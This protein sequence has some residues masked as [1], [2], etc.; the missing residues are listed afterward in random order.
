M[1]KYE[2]GQQVMNTLVKMKF[3]GQMLFIV[4]YFHTSP[5]QKNTY[6]E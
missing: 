6:I 3:S 2:T 5:N 4:S 1:F